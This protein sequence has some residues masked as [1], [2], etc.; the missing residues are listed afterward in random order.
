MRRSSEE[1]QSMTT[2]NIPP[3]T[4]T[5]RQD[6]DLMQGLVTT[7]A[8]VALADGRVQTVERDELVNFMQQ[9]MPAI[10]GDEIGELF[11]HRVR[12]LR[13]RGAV[14]VITEKLRPLAGLSLAS[15]VVRTAERIAAADR[16]IHPNELQAIRLIRLF[17]ASLPAKK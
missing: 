9:L 14:A 3:S 17:M 4:T 2:L 5:N 16:Q 11:D 10:S 12:E 15:V 1:E 6:E 13:D 7:G 8:L